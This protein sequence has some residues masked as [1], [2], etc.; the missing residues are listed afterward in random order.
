MVVNEFWVLLLSAKNE[1]LGIKLEKNMPVKR[2]Q[3]LPETDKGSYYT[4]E[5][6]EEFLDSKGAFYNVMKVIITMR[7]IMKI[8]NSSRPRRVFPILAT[9]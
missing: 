6:L 4:E 9:K 2:S 5:W 7:V 8:T 1:K 3:N